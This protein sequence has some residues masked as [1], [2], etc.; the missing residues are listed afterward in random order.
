[1]FGLFPH[2]FKLM[3]LSRFVKQ[4]RGPGLSAPTRKDAMDL[5]R[6]LLA[7]GTITPVIDSVYALSEAR[8]AIRH[9]IEDEVRG[10]VIITMGNRCIVG[11]APAG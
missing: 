9:M 7:A 10:K 3:F 6:E 4:L 8:E 5:L 1:M 11:R 2:F